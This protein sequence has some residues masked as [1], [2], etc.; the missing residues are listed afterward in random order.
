MIPVVRNLLAPV[1]PSMTAKDDR[2][3]TAEEAWPLVHARSS[4]LEWL[5]SHGQASPPGFW[6]DQPKDEW[7]LLLQGQATLLF[8]DGPL[9]LVAGDCLTIP[10]R[11]RHR[12]E[13]VSD[14]ARWL[15]L[16]FEAR[17]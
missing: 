10:A 4:R 2:Q 5:V 13:R 16:H 1:A 17:S 3:R 14:D 11:L 8:E 15:A 6:Y 12:V 9:E 7:V